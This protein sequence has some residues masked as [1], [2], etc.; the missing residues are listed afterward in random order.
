MLSMMQ[1]HAQPRIQPDSI[2]DTFGL[3]AL[4][5]V[6][7]NSVLKVRLQYTEFLS[8]SYACRVSTFTNCFS[9]L[10]LLV[11]VAQTKKL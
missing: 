3:S 2:G 4:G 1:A 5:Q 11:D 6:A 7:C 8:H 10:P 9:Q